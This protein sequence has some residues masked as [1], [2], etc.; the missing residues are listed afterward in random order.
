MV[1]LA[2]KEIWFRGI[3]HLICILG[4][5]PFVSKLRKAESAQ[6]SVPHEHRDDP[7]TVR[8]KPYQG[9]CNAPDP[10]QPR[11]RTT[12]AGVRRD[13]RGG[14]AASLR[15]RFQA[16]Y[17]TWNLFR[18]SGVASFLPKRVRTPFGGMT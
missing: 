14:T 2:R 12:G 3:F 4:E 6:Q 9:R 7:G 10:G 15:A 8:L 17:M 18:K 1:S 11:R 13:W 5:S 16:V